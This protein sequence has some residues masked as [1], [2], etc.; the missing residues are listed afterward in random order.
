[1]TDDELDA[2]LDELMRREGVMITMGDG[3]YAD[4]PIGERTLRTHYFELGQAGGQDLVLM[5]T[6]GVGVSAYMCWRQNLETFA[7]AGYR[8]LAPD[9]PGFGY[10]ESASAVSDRDFLKAFLDAMGV[11]SAHLVGNS[12][13]AM[14]ALRVACDFP[15]YV[16]T[17]TI[18]GGEPRADTEEARPIIPNLG[19]TPRNNFV[20]EMFAK[21]ELLFED[22]RRAT[23]DF[24]YDRSH[25][26]I[27]RVARLRFDSLRDPERLRLARDRSLNQPARRRV[28]A[29]PLAL[30]TLQMPTLLLHGRDEPWF[31]P[32]DIEPALIRAAVGAAFEIPDCRCVLLP[33]CGHWPQ[34]EQ[35]DTYNAI[36]LQFLGEHKATRSGTRMY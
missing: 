5:H 3:K 12:M 6:G 2:G 33:Q 36:V 9:A 26:A 30:D 19:E 1:M 11:T 10:T 13:G 34:L 4:V 23:A 17:L 8:V 24:F 29:E 35:P 16:R 31:Y 7:R 27:D 32:K 18:S 22:M 15:A 21:P 25:P 20:R 14:A 28:M